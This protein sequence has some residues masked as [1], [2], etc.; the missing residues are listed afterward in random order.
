MNDCLTTLDELA[1]WEDDLQVEALSSIQSATLVIIV[2][3]G[4]TPLPGTALTTYV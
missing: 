3:P 4:W 2:F 1:G